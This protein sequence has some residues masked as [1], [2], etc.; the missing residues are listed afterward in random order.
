MALTVEQLEVVSNLTRL[1]HTQFYVA[2]ALGMSPQNLSELKKN[3]QDVKDVLNVSSDGLLLDV[4]AR[5]YKTAIKG[6]DRD[7][8]AA[9]SFLL[10]RYEKV[11]DKPQDVVNDADIAQSILDD[12]K[13]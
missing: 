12:L 11:E 7:S 1:G 6:K 2:Q 4:K 3:H 5:M 10:N 8:T 9:A 13:E